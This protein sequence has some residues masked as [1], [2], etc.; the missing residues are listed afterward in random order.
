MKFWNP[1]ILKTK[2]FWTALIGIAGVG[3]AFAFGEIKLPEALL[4]VIGLIQSINI[5][6]GMMPD[7][8]QATVRIEDIGSVQ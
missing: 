6:S 2:S 4:T 1:E 7:A 5:R 3:I 8:V